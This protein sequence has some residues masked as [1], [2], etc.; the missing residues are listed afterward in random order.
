MSLQDDLNNG[1]QRT[2]Y[3]LYFGSFTDGNNDDDIADFESSENWGTPGNIPMLEVTYYLPS[4]RAVGGYVAPVNKLAVLMPY[5][6]LSAL[7]VVVSTVAV[8]RRRRRN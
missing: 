8:V 6:A 3:K 4:P 2:Q 5:L 1:R 7:V